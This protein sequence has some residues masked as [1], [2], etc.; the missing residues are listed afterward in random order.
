M[1]KKATFLQILLAAVISV[2]I[3]AYGLAAAKDKLM[4]KYLPV[5]HDIEMVRQENNTTDNPALL[6][7][8]QTNNTETSRIVKGHIGCLDCRKF[9]MPG[10]AH[11]PDCCLYG[12]NNT[13]IHCQNMTDPDCRN[14]LP[15]PFD[16]SCVNCT[17][18]FKRSCCNSGGQCPLWPANYSNC[19]YNGCPG[20]TKPMNTTCKQRPSEPG[21]WYCKNDFKDPKQGCVSKNSMVKSYNYTYATAYGA[22][23]AAAASECADANITA[24]CYK[25]TPTEAFKNDIANC[26]QQTKDWEALYYKY[27]NATLGQSICN[28]TSCYSGFD[29][30]CDVKECEAKIKYGCGN[31]TVSACQK[32]EEDYREML[33]GNIADAFQ[34]I[35]PGFRYKFV[36]R[37]GERYMISWQILCDVREADQRYNLYTMVKVWDQEQQN[38]FIYKPVYQSIVHQKALGSTFYIN[39]QTGMDSEKR[40]VLIPGHA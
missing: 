14:P 18:T 36:A 30:N 32:M 1:V 15:W 21:N 8:R 25:Y 11:C 24:P 27:N 38:E 17:G 13:L 19:L 7:V 34:E 37:S 39:A 9:D 12:A 16:S 29:Q 20:S 23:T 4:L 5:D 28:Y 31:Y 3:G 26:S 40:S 6:I 22:A 10:G 33:L 35:D 2:I